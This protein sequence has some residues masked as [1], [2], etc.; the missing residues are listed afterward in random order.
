MKQF[1][2]DNG[3]LVKLLVKEHFIMLMAIFMRVNGLTTK[4]MVKECIQTLKEQS[5]RVTGEKI[6][7]TDLELKHGM[8]D[9]DMKVNMLWVRKREEVNI[10]GLMA[11]SMMEIG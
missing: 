3:L 8:R 4:L 1:T 7:S 5:M 11:L 2:K 6:I 9:Q 10:C